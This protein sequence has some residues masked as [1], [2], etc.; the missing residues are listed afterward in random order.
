[1]KYLNAAEPMH[2]S[3]KEWVCI[4]LSLN[5]LFTLYSQRRTIKNTASKSAEFFEES[6]LYWSPASDPN[7]LY[8]QMAAKKYREI[9]RHQIQ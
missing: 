1:M 6:D 3:A 7:E 8:D 4:T 5:C 9:P 2:K